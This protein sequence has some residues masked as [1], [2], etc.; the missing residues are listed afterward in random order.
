MSQPNTPPDWEALAARADFKALLRDKLTF[1][2]P[3]CS[4]FIAYYFTLP[5]LC[6]WFPAMMT[7][8]I[9][10]PFNAAYLF[11]LSQFFMAW[12]LAWIYVRRAS[13]W[14]VKAAQIIK[15]SE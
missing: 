8:R 10:G 6:G 5:V 3:A 1:I 7:K 11:A 2:V 9:L 13:Q 14:D 12:V 4:F 15:G